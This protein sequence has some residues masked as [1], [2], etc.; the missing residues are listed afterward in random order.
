MKHSTGLLFGDYVKIVYF[1]ERQSNT[2]L[3]TQKQN[4][5]L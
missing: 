3:L 2:V 5:S 1:K 4:L